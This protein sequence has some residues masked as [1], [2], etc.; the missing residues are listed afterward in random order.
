MSTVSGHFP[1]ALLAASIAIVS[2]N[3]CSITKQKAAV[4]AYHAEA[5][6]SGRATA[7]ID[8]NDPVLAQRK[9]LLNVA[10]NELTSR[11]VVAKLLY[12]DKLND[13]PIDLLLSTPGGSFKDTFGI[14]DVMRSLRAPVN[15]WALG[16]CNSAGALLLAAGTGRRYAFSNAIIII[17]GVKPAGKY[18][19]ELDRIVQANYA[20]VWKERTRL[21]EG[22]F[23]LHAEK[24][25]FLTPEQGLEYG[26][27]D[28]IAKPVKN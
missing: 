16:S 1:K 17:H 11:E 9:I 7:T 6:E 14:I 13:S 23:P 4:P 12:L 20:R 22:W 21:P 27:I 3:G 5:I 24:V 8:Y 28:E 10:V 15:T 25:H 2:G 26:V 18:P 19:P